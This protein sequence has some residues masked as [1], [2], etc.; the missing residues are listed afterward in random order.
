MC[1]LKDMKNIDFFNNHMF[2]SGN[3]VFKGLHN[4]QKIYTMSKQFT[5]LS[6]CLFPDLVAS[7]QT[8]LFHFNLLATLFEL[9][10]LLA[11][12]QANSFV[13]I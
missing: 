9:F 13:A 11:F 8:S 5:P 6:K 7:V 10:V 4:Y 3:W 1:Y 2:L 12:L